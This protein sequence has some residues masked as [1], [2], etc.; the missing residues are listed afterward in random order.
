MAVDEATVMQELID[1][2]DI[3]IKKVSFPCYVSMSML[4][5]VF[6]HM[7]QTFNVCGTLN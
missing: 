4:V 7:F 6:L 1:E 3:E 2:R 5:S